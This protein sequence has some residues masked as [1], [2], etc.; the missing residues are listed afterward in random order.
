MREAL[1]TALSGGHALT[2]KELSASL[3]VSERELGPHLQ[4]LKRSLR[5]RDERLEVQP[6]RCLVCGFTFED[7]ARVKRPGRCPGCRGTRIAPP[8]FALVVDR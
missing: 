3:R 5:H 7:R 2:I 4:H 1:V 8:R 6:A